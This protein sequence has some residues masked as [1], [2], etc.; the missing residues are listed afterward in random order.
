MMQWCKS[1]SGDTAEVSPSNKPRVEV[2]EVRV[3]VRERRRRRSVQTNGTIEVL[4][5]C[6]SMAGLT[7]P[8]P[9]F[10]FLRAQQLAA[11]IV[12]AYQLC[13]MLDRTS[14]VP[15][16][17]PHTGAVQSTSCVSGPNMHVDYLWFTSL[18][19]NSSIF[20][21]ISIFCCFSRPLRSGF[22]LCQLQA[23]E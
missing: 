16:I 14:S 1:N 10:P 22:L 15:H 9:S 7:S 21:V 4:L 6:C 3:R 2:F 12:Q 11:Q 19:H 20:Q 8:L 18:S 23:T 5:Q 17:L 13:Y